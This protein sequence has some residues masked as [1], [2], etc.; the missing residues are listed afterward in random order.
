MNLTQIQHAERLGI[1][2]RQFRRRVVKFGLEPVDTNGPEP[3]YDVADVDDM[4]RA[5]KAQELG[6]FKSGKGQKVLTVREA[7]R[8]AGKQLR[9]AA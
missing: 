2:T 3:L 8:R 5:R 1:S 7:K 4:E 6:K 9:R